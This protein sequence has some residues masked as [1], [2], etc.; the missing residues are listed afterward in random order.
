MELMGF[1]EG[2][3]LLR[4]GCVP[5]L[6]YVFTPV[7]K[8]IRL[9]LQSTSMI[10]DNKIEVSQEERPAC[11]AMVQCPGGGEILQVLVITKDSDLMLGPIQVMSPLFKSYDY[12][13]EF[14]VVDIVIDF[15]RG[16]LSGIKGNWVEKA[17]RL[18]LRENSA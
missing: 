2:C 1:Q 13:K 17:V 11:L 8:S 7:R 4:Q 10:G 16:E 6:G 15:G 9:P 12:G 14:L 5:S 18:I 3:L